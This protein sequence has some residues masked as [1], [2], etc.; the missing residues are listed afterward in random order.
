MKEL[1]FSSNPIHINLS[2]NLLVDKIFI[3]KCFFSFTLQESLGRKH[4]EKIPVFRKDTAKGTMDP[5]VE[6]LI[7]CFYS[8]WDPLSR[9]TCQYLQRLKPLVDYLKKMMS[10]PNPNFIF[11]TFNH[12]SL[13]SLTAD[14]EAI[15]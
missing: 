4:F 8:T 9:N 15:M 11:Y 5:G 1:T 7:Q 13:F 10:K 12:Q 6:F 2:T 14:A 3:V